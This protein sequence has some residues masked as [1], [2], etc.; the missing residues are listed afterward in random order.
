MLVVALAI[1]AFCATALDE[2]VTSQALGAV[3]LAQQRAFLAAASGL[4]RATEQLRH[5]PA[6]APMELAIEPPDRLTIEAY[7]TVRSAL[8]QGFSAGQFAEQHYELRS[9]GLS[10]RGAH[11]VQVMGLRRLE[12]AEPAAPVPP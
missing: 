9:T 4:N 3:R 12:L 5:S 6:F 8:P 10:A 2:A 11:S 7:A 1:A